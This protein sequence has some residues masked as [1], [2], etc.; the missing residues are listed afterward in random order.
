MLEKGIGY[1]WS[2]VSQ[3]SILSDNYDYVPGPSEFPGY[4]LWSFVVRELD[5]I[6]SN[7]HH[8]RPLRA[9]EI[10]PARRFY[11]R[12]N[13]PLGMQIRRLKRL[14]EIAG[15]MALVLDNDAIIL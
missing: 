5:K 8:Y 13:C 1:I 7:P 15:K 9:G 11:N 4:A 14:L 3:V 6:G 10:P 2:T 12:A